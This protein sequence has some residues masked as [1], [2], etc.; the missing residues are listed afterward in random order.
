MN[1]P[2]KN[3]QPDSVVNDKNLYLCF[4]H[5]KNKKYDEAKVLIQ[6][7]LDQSAKTKDAQAQAL[8]L[9]AMGV[10]F[11][12]QGDYKQSYK[13]YQKAE[14]LLP[15]DP[16]LKIISAT[17]LIEEFGQH[18]TA[19]KKLEKIIASTETDA[20]ILHHAQVLVGLA[21]AQM[22]KMDAAQKKLRDINAQDFLVLRSATN[23]NFKL[24]EFLVK[25]K[26]A[27]DAC[28]TFLNKA[29]ELAIQKR[30]LPYQGAIQ[31][32]LGQI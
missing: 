20:A 26:Q 25:K 15:D 8:Y 24:V 29:R 14:K 22:G 7:G 12:V 5:I 21:L 31:S 30:E 27:K 1:Q 10:L 16:A 19:L 28:I 32:L 2:P 6:S 11:K 4:Q 3:N 13:F 23:L 9:S 18:D 17:L